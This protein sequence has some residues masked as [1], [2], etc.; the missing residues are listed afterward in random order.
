MKVM[1]EASWEPAMNH[2]IPANAD[3]EL[4]ERA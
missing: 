1:D 4:L 3:I 2:R